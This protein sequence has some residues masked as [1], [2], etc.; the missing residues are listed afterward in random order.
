MPIF[1]D[2]LKKDHILPQK[3][4]FEWDSLLDNILT[5]SLLKIK[6]FFFW[7]RFFFK[8]LLL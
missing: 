6:L 5:P 4:V 7:L 1:V 2:T 3:R 8:S